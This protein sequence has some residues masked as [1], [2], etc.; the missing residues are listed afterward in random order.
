MQ[1]VKA[2]NAI[3]T[4]DKNFNAFSLVYSWNTRLKPHDWFFPSGLQPAKITNGMFPLAA[5][6][7]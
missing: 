4:A 1:S 3:C 6:I 7:K 5:I 2:I